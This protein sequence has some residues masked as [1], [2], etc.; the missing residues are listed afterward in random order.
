M[1]QYNAQWD[2]FDGMNSDEI[3]EFRRSD[4]TGHRPTWPMAT[5]RAFRNVWDSENLRD[6][7]GVFGDH[8]A[9]GQKANGGAPGAAPVNDRE[10]LAVLNLEPAATRADIKIR[11]KELVKRHHPDVNGGDRS[12][13]E[14]LKHVIKAYRLLLRSRPA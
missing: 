9:N 10:A 8:G 2:F 1:R 4:V 13:E 14:R 3:E 11:F 6:L 12:A 5:G 7:F